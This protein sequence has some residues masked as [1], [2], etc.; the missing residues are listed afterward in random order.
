MYRKDLIWVYG[1]GAVILLLTGYLLWSYEQPDWK[2]YQEEFR[3]LIAEK[4]GEQRAE[5]VPATP[6]QVCHLWVFKKPRSRL[7]ASGLRL[8]QVQTVGSLFDL[9]ETP[10]PLSCRDMNEL[11]TAFLPPKINLTGAL[12]SADAYDQQFP[13]ANSAESLG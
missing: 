1:F 13:T 9:V 12:A 5:Q 4:F 11:K 3:G 2:A 6:H 8:K 10:N 7:K